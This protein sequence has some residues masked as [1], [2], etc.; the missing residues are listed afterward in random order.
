MKY[1][2]EPEKYL[3]SAGLRRKIGKRFASS[4]TPNCSNM[5]V[6]E[7]L[8]ELNIWYLFCYKLIL[9]GQPRC[10]GTIIESFVVRNIWLYWNIEGG[11]HLSTNTT[12][13]MGNPL[14]WTWDSPAQIFGYICYQFNELER[15]FYSPVLPSFCTIFRNTSLIRSNAAWYADCCLCL[16]SE[17]HF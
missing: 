8:L 5:V 17:R 15:N 12:L 9:R 1:F 6:V 11:G 10:T 14:Y 2:L 3:N 7:I 4:R 16:C 13:D